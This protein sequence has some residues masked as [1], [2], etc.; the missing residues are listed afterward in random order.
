MI[1]ALKGLSWLICGEMTMGYQ[2]GSREEAKEIVS[3]EMM[4]VTQG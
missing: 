2:G 4:V 3:Q 1:L